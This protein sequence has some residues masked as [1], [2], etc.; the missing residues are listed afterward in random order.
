MGEVRAGHWL[1][2]EMRC[3]FAVGSS[4]AAALRL[5]EAWS[6]SGF[7]GESELQIALR[8]ARPRSSPRVL[9]WEHDMEVT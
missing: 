3:V 8:S 1:E 4:R 2:T 9:T 7:D 5:Q 6:L